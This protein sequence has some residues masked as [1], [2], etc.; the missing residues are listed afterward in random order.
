MVDYECRLCGQ[1]F[2][3]REDKQTHERE[4]H[5]KTLDKFGIKQPKF[6]SSEFENKNSKQ[7]KLDVY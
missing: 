1:I 6:E 7:S 4:S 2:N 5:T 3:F